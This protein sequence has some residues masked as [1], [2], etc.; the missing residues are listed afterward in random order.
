MWVRKEGSWGGKT[1]FPWTGGGNGQGGG[2]AVAHQ[3]ACPLHICEPQGIWGPAAFCS[4]SSL[5]PWVTAPHPHL[6]SRQLFSGPRSQGPVAGT[7]NVRVSFDWGQGTSSPLC[8][9]EGRDWRASCLAAHSPAEQVVLFIFLHL[10]YKIVPFTKTALSPSTT[11][12]AQWYGI[13][14]NCKNISSR[15]DRAAE[16]ATKQTFKH[17]PPFGGPAPRDQGARGLAAQPL[18]LLT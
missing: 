10:I 3:W 12:T 7:P 14:L 8:G 6:Q 18:T 13:Q 9:E 11:S 1:H 16:I 4:L 2:A 5:T 15:C 17:P